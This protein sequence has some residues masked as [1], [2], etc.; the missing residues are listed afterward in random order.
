MRPELSKWENGL[1][2]KEPQNFDF[3]FNH[4]SSK[5]R[6]KKEHQKGANG[7]H[8]IYKKATEAFKSGLVKLLPKGFRLMTTNDYKRGA[9]TIQKRNADFVDAYERF[10][11]HRGHDQNH[12]KI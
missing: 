10:L 4:S 12:P 6:N 1:G 8:G 9:D 3:G 11:Q 2:F 5:N 7:V